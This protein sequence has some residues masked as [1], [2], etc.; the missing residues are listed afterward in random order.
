MPEAIAARSAPEVDRDTDREPPRSGGPESVACLSPHIST[1]TLIGVTGIEVLR[2]DVR[3]RVGIRPDIQLIQSRKG[4]GGIR[5]ACREFS[6]R[7]RMN[8]QEVVRNTEASWGS[9]LC[10][11][12]PK[13]FPCDGLQVK[14]HLRAFQQA[15]RR[16]Y[17]SGAAYLWFLEFQKRGAPHI[18]FLMESGL[19]ID[20][21]W[22]ASNWYRIVGSGDIS[23]YRVHR[24][25]KQWQEVYSAD[26]CERY[27]A[28]YA[29]KTFQKEVPEGFQNVGRF[30][31]HPLHV[32]PKVYAVAQL[33][34]AELINMVGI[35]K[36]GRFIG[37]K[38][39]KIFLRCRRLWDLADDAHL[40]IVGREA[41]S[42][43]LPRM[44]P[45]MIRIRRDVAQEN[46]GEVA[47][48]SWPRGGLSRSDRTPAGVCH[49]LTYSPRGGGR[50]LTRPP[51][52]QSRAPLA[53]LLDYEA[54][55]G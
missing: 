23:H 41:L 38:N 11:S 4:F 13:E 52:S 35:E 28:K 30:W 43:P 44:H 50:G 14:K 7:S 49:N 29:H 12:Y 54:K 22:L 10:L 18:H 32:K 40:E 37:T 45:V 1:E 53:H 19:E 42:T 34:E 15:I 33:D 8:L 27:V 47:E 48:G 26:G 21:E 25:I 39:G 3:V 51:Q 55:S 20:R 16:R 5:G 36:I 46:G 24:H 9:M 6:Q 31:G 17:G 2:K